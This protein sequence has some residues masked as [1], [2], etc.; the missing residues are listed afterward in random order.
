MA[1][2]SRVDGKDQ[3]RHSKASAL[4]SVRDVDENA[5]T[6]S[7]LPQSARHDVVVNQAVADATNRVVQRSS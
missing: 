3:E 4:L 7:A 1:S 2:V 5:R 6:V